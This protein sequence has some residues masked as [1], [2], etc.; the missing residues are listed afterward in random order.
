MEETAKDW[1]SMVMVSSGSRRP[2]W[3]INILCSGGSFTRRQWRLLKTPESEH[4]VPVTGDRAHCHSL[5]S[6]Q[7]SPSLHGNSCQ[8]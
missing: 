1:N 8:Q 4:L 6:P 7:S 2:A 3:H 5:A